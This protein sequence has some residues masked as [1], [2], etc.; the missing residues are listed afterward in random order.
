MKKAIVLIAVLLTTAV[1]Y[2]T[3]YGIL[4]ND[5]MFYEADPLGEQDYQGREQYKASVS[6][7]AGDKWCIYDED[8]TAKFT[9][10]MESG[11]GSAKGNFT[12][13]K[14]YVTCNTAGCYD[15]YI[16]LKWEDNSMWVQAGSNC[17]DS[18]RDI[19]PDGGGSTPGGGSIDPQ[20]FTTAVPSQSTDV[21]LQAFYWDSYENKGYGDTKWATLV[22]K[23]PEWAPYFTLVWLPP[24]AESKGGLGYIPSRYSSQSSTALGK[25][26]YLNNL[27]T[28]LHNANI[29]VIA[30]IVINHCGNASSPC[31]Y[32][33]LDFG[34]YGKFNPTSNWMTSND[35]GVS[36]YG[37]SGGS[38][39]DD[40]QHNANYGAARDWDH[41]NPQVQAMCRAY[42]KWMKNEVKYDGFRFDYCGGY[43]TSHINDYVSNAKPY[44]SVMEYW[45]G[46]AN[47]L[48]SRIDDANKNTLA[49]DFALMYAA[50]HEGIAVNNYNKLTNA[51]L[52]GKG[53][54]KYAVTFIDNHDTFNRPDDQNVSDVCGK[55]DGSSINNSSVILQ[56]NAY[57]LSLP[58]IPCVFYPHWIKYNAEIKKMITAR[59]MA[60]IHSESTMTESA[61][62]G[63]YEAT[64]QGKY[65]SVVLY[66]GSS[67]SKSA[68]SGYTE[69]AKG[70]GYAMYYTGNGPQAVDQ[71]VIESP[72]LQL[73]APIYNIMGQQVDANYKG[74]VIQNGNKYLLQ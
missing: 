73:D 29:R 63:Y 13:G 45:H 50:F 62:S 23:V 42:L 19:T 3:T 49:F 18:G 5:K 67:A 47:Q 59:K 53:Y 22:N 31:D 41:K 71:T 21:M 30:D 1:S 46:D 61:G 2:A 34:S 10:A 37:C 17:S 57:M 64:I 72:T 54:S 11:E 15:F 14:D 68:P 28:A 66:L 56:C 60:G 4:V 38:N 43:H 44:F 26:Q 24:S 7:N 65:G 69:G 33:S 70:S 40:G 27:I 32:N 9:I 35:E 6:L 12:E 16:K 51:G 36:Q 52:R 48:K 20:D 74:F 25:R 39:A 55:H 58:G 8:N